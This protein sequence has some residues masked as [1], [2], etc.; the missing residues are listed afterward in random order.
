MTYLG[1]VLRR[2]QSEL[3][4]NGIFQRLTCSVPLESA[5]KSKRNYSMECNPA[6]EATCSHCNII[7]KKKRKNSH[8]CSVECSK[9]Q[10][11]KKKSDKIFAKNPDAIQCKICNLYVDSAIILHLNSK[12]N[13]NVAEYKKKFNMDENSSEGIISA[14]FSKKL[15][16]KI[17]GEKNPGYQHGGKFSTFSKNNLKYVNMTEEEKEETIQTAFDSIVRPVENMTIKIE[18]YLSRGMTEEEAKLALS[19]RQTTFSLEKCVEKLGEE[20]G[21]KRWQERQ[22]KWHKNFKKSN[23]SKISQVLYVELAKDFPSAIYATSNPAKLNSEFIFKTKSGSVYKLDFYIQETGHIIEFDGD[24]WHSEKHLT[25][26]NKNRDAE[27]D[28][29]ILATDGKLKIH[30]VKECDFKKDPTKVIE[31][32]KKFLET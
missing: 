22:E 4:Q 13:M 12:H 18:Y 9:A 3:S 31:E 2:Q 1:T 16:E 25:S 11:D 21:L 17:V 27:R 23:F 20:A 26:V 8:T 10:N 24:Y 5:T 14:K 32:C 19:K 30:H 29:A 15:S 6:V 28:A 7:L